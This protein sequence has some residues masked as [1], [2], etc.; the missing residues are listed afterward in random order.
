[1]ADWDMLRRLRAD[2]SHESE[3][4]KV[5]L[6]EAAG[7]EE[8]HSHLSS[9]L[10]HAKTA[11]RDLLI[12]PS[13]APTPPPSPPAAEQP[14]TVDEI[15]LVIEDTQGFGDTVD[16]AVRRMRDLARTHAGKRLHVR[17]WVE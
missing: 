9:A 14:E 16:D 3:S 6:A 7:A 5:E 17:W 10:E 13:A 1:G 15:D 2:T 11:S 4:I 8:M 12:K